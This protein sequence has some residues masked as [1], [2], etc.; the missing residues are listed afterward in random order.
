V[1]FAR[2]SVLVI[3]THR[4]ALPRTFPFGLKGVGTRGLGFA[5]TQLPSSNRTVS[6]EDGDGRDR[7]ADE[8]LE[9]N[10]SHFCLFPSVVGLRRGCISATTPIS[11]LQ[12]RWREE[13]FG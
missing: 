4:Q 10:A 12:R 7:Y 9:K 3:F 1:P 13:Q 6:T 2:W 5:D 8:H 11:R